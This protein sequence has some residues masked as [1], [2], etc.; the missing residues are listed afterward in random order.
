MAGKVQRKGKKGSKKKVVDPYSKKEWYAVQ[1]PKMFKTNNLGWTLVNRSAGMRNCL[2]D[3]KGR[4]FQSSLGDLNQ[5]EE[6]SFRKFFFKVED[7]INSECLT[8]FHGMSITTDKLKS[9][10]KKW[11][12]LIEANLDV[13]TTDGYLVRLFVIGF[14]KKRQRQVKK[15]CYAQSAQIRQIR[16]RA[17]D[18]LKK[19]ANCQLKELVQKLSP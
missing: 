19:E 1:A 7:T 12:S 8:T 2:D 9:M 5:D 14:T 3:L 11:Q 16:Q 18:V 13:K 4:V 17:F 15:T 10:V 6:Q